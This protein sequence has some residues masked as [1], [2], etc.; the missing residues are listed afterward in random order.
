MKQVGQL[1]ITE[2]TRNESK[3]F[4]SICFTATGNSLIAFDSAST[5]FICRLSPI[6]EPGGLVTIPYAV[7]VLEYCLLTGIDYWDILIGLRANMPGY[8]PDLGV[9]SPIL[10]SSILPHGKYGCHR[11]TLPH[12]NSTGSIARSGRQ[13]N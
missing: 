5:M 9:D 11:H 2:K 7:M 13:F 6:T 1:S 10:P 4:T 8:I 3:T 12:F